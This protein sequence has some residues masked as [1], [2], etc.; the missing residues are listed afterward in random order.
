M[1]KALLHNAV[2]SLITVYSGR[3]ILIRLQGPSLSNKAI[4]TGLGS[5]KD[6][7]I[8]PINRSPLTCSAY[9][10]A[11]NHRQCSIQ[12]SSDGSQ[13]L[14]PPSHEKHLTWSSTPI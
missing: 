11:G 10:Q 7:C 1:L 6:A 5:S 2:S 9:E 8:L 12:G 3:L 14:S 13:R 4:D